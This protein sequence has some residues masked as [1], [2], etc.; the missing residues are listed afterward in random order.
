MPTVI[1][2]GVKRDALSMNTLDYIRMC[3]GARGV[4]APS[5]MSVEVIGEV[6]MSAKKIDEFGQM[7]G[8]V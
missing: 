1:A 8:A 5:R 3:K 6:E 7:L 4:R 2:E